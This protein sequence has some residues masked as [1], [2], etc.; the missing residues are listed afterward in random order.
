M[1]HSCSPVPSD[2]G[3]LFGNLGAYSV[4]PTPKAARL[5]LEMERDPSCL[6]N[7]R[8]PDSFSVTLVFCYCLGDGREFNPGVRWSLTVLA[9][10]ALSGMEF[11]LE[12][13]PRL[14]RARWPRL[15]RGGTKERECS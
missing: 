14:D 13:I 3:V 10:G 5:V 2:D 7:N 11:F 9:L 1:S 8:I 4:L 12:V 15:T 6:E